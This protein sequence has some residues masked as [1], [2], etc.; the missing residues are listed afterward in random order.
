MGL[1]V[2]HVVCVCVVHGVA[3]LPREVRHQHR[4]LFFFSHN[5]VWRGPGGG[6][7][8]AVGT[9][10]VGNNGDGTQREERAHVY[11]NTT[12]QNF[13]LVLY[14]LN[15]RSLWGEYSRIGAGLCNCRKS[16]RSPGN[17]RFGACSSDPRVKGGKLPTERG[18]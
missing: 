3:A 16:N 5:N 8:W 1:A 15:Y 11:S 18:A 13:L 12:I 4:R 14:P 2:F 7:G 9:G 17:P 6:V 10:G